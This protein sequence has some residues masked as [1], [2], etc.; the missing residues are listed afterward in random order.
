MTER[1]VSGIRM[2]VPLLDLQAQYRTIAPELKAAV[3]RVLVSQRFINGPEVSELERR[4][5]EYCACGYAVGA[6]SGTDAL[7]MALMV[8]GVGPGDEVVTTPFTF[9]STAGTI[10]RLG[11][12]PVFVDI[13]PQTYNLD[14]SRIED[15]LTDRTRA[16]LPV[17]LYGQTADMDPI[18]ALANARSVPVIEDAAQSL[19]ARYRGRPAGSMGALG[20]F[21]FYPSKN[22]GAIGDAGMVVTQDEE[23]A[24]ALRHCRSH[25]EN[26]KYFHQ[27]VGGNFRLDTL[28]AAALLVKLDHLDRWHAARRDNARRY[29]GLFADV[30]AVTTPRIRPENETIYNQYVIRVPRARDCVDFLRER[31]VGC[32]V[33]YPL[34]LHQQECFLS[35]GYRKGDFPESEKAAEQTLAIPIYPELTGEQID[36]VADQVKAFVRS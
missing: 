22:L 12:R 26:Q 33:Y 9:F 3:D 24:G 35:L 7:L 23:L 27:T 18:L 30:D 8:L 17:H 13:D 21:S 34:S 10:W 16:I 25:G 11:A 5:A 1:T 28:Q 29:D 36:Y 2:Q 4:I 6:S 19:G 31:G 20:C 32:E 15:A 14:A